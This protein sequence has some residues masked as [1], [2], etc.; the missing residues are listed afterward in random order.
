MASMRQ[1]FGTYSLPEELCY[2]PHVESSFND[3]ARS[4]VGASGLWQFMPDTGKMFMRV[5]SHIDERNDPFAATE[6]ATRMEQCGMDDG[7]AA[8]DEGIASARLA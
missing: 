6:A 3:R 8:F 5:D 4:K 7:L 2:L 1:I